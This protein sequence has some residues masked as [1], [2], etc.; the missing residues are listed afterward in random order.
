MLNLLNVGFVGS[1]GSSSNEYESMY[2][3]RSKLTTV[4]KQHMVEWFSGNQLPSYLN[5]THNSGS[6]GTSAMSDEVDGGYAFSASAG[7][8][9]MTVLNFNDKRIFSNTGST[10]I[11][12]AKILSAKQGGWGL[13][14]TISA[15]V[16]TIKVVVTT[17]GNIMLYSANNSTES[18]TSTTLPIANGYNFHTYKLDQSSSSSS[19]SIDGFYNVTKTTHQSTTGMQPMAYCRLSNSKT[20]VRYCEAYNT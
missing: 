8:S 6:G 18:G 5:F 1:A 16:N 12:V 3:S 2:Q 9:D 15:S 17:S 4:Q 19:L 14:G 13:M 11:W 7:G 20:T 10:A